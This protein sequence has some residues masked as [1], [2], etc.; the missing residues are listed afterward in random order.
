MPSTMAEQVMRLQTTIITHYQLVSLTRQSKL[1]HIAPSKTRPVSPS[2]SALLR[3]N[4]H[5]MG[6]GNAKMITSIETLHETMDIHR[7]SNEMHVT[8]TV[9]AHIDEIGRH[10]RSK[11]VQFAKNQQVLTPK[12]HQQK[13]WNRGCTNTRLL[14]IRIEL[15]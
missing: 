6:S 5:V 15:L 10:S 8:A 2:L 11:A 14:S 12:T 7:L 13:T 1:T 4:F 3:C 9:A